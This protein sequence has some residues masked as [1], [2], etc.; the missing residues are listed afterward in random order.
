M[1][2]RKIFIRFDINHDNVTYGSKLKFIK[3][4]KVIS[5]FK[6]KDMRFFVWYYKSKGVYQVVERKSGLMCVESKVS[7]EHAR[8]KFRKLLNK[9][10]VDKLKRFRSKAIAYYNGMLEQWYYGKRCV[11][12]GE[13]NIKKNRFKRRT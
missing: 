3:D 12:N 6:V 5:R 9:N 4:S 1:K 13:T 2:K 10:S 11:K 7:V 8:K